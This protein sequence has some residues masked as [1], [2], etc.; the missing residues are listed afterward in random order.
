MT[1]D[2]EPIGFETRL[3]H[4]RTGWRAAYLWHAVLLAAA[5]G[6]IIGALLGFLTARPAPARGPLVKTELRVACGVVRT[7]QETGA[8]QP[9]AANPPPAAFSWTAS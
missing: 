5:T 6:T 4:F 7:S 3:P 1:R 8:L 2:L 9:A